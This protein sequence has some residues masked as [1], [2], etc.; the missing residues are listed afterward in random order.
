MAYSTI[1]P[2]LKSFIRKDIFFFKYIFK[3]ILV[4]YSHKKM[5]NTSLKVLM[6]IFVV[7]L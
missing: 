7:N 1:I 4:K 5:L 2:F 3:K 6:N